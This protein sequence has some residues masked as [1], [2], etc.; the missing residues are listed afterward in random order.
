MEQDSP[1][2][3]KSLLSHQLTVMVEQLDRTVE[4]IVWKRWCNKAM[5]VL[6]GASDDIIKGD[7]SYIEIQIANCCSLLLKQALEVTCECIL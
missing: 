2:L 7:L 3:R 6:T 4:V 5:S 1:H